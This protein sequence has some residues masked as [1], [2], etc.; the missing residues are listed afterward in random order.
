MSWTTEWFDEM[1][2]SLIEPKGH[3]HRI[4][5]RRYAIGDLARALGV[6]TRRIRR[7][8]RN[9]QFP[10]T[11]HWQEGTNSHSH[12][13]QYT[14]HMID[15][16]V[17]IA[18]ELGLDRKRRWDLSESDFG[19]RVSEAWYR[20]ERSEEPWAGDRGWPDANPK[21]II[22][23]STPEKL[24]AAE[25]ARLRALQSRRD[26]GV[27]DMSNPEAREAKKR[28]EPINLPRYW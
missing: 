14:M 13:R 20:T 5:D 25:I 3:A 1:F 17:D 24:R 21:N 22:D 26:D 9:G 12:R 16:T 19:L 15:V 2:G 8:I 4:V 10:E 23:C 27:I 11:P 7:W 18:R 28:G 6:P